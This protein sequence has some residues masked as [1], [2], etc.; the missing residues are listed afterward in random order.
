MLRL[1]SKIFTELQNQ[2]GPSVSARK[3]TW[4]E[5]AA[6]R[7]SF[8]SGDRLAGMWVPGQARFAQGGKVLPGTCVP[9]QNTPVP[10]TSHTSMRVCTHL[11]TQVTRY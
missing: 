8:G 4:P 1:L 10:P 3:D 9:S 6:W 11:L 5:T 2:S 7:G